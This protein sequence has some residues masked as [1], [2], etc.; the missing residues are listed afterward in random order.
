MS[1]VPNFDP[2]QL[3]FWDIYVQEEKDATIKVGGTMAG[4]FTPGLSGGQRKLFLFE[5]IYQRTLDHSGLLI[6][7][8]EPFAGVTDD[9]LPYIKKRLQQL[10]ERHAVIVVTNDHIDAL[11]G[12]ANHR[13]A[14]SA[15]DRSVVEIN[16]LGTFDREQVIRALHAGNEFRYRT[17]YE[18]FKF[19]F[20]LE[21]L[22]HRIF[23]FVLIYA[24]VTH[25]LTILTFWDS[26]DN[27]A[28]LVLSGSGIGGFFCLNVYYTS[29]VSWRT[30]MEQERDALLHD[31]KS[32]NRILKTILLAVA[33][34]LV[35][36]VA[37]Y[38]TANIVLGDVYSG[39]TMFVG[40]LTAFFDVVCL[41]IVLGVYTSYSF[42]TV[43]IYAALPFLLSNFLSTTMSPGG[44][45]PIVKELRYLFPRFYMWCMLPGVENFM[46]GCPENED[47][48]AWYMILSSLTGL[49]LFILG[50]C[51]FAVVPRTITKRTG[52][53]NRKPLEHASHE[54]EECK[55]LQEILYGDND[56]T[57]S[58]YHGH[59]FSSSE[60]L[61][62]FYH[63]TVQESKTMTVI[64]GS[65]G[66]GKTTF[67]EDV[68]RQNKCVYI[69]QFHSMRPYIPVTKI[70]NFD[71]T[72][73]PFWEIYASDEKDPSIQVG[74]TMAGVFTPGLSGGQRKLLLFELVCQRIEA[75]SGLLI[76]LD[77]PFAG[78]TEDFLLYIMKRLNEMRQ[79][80]NVILVTNDHVTHL[81]KLANCT[82]SLS[83]K[84]R[85]MVNVNDVED[86]DREV[87]ILA[88]SMGQPFA[89][90]ATDHDL[91]FF[92]DV[93]S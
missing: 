34:L 72:R 85:E 31:S 21:V 65:S 8:D 6:A 4:H 79:K 40:T 80:H 37:Q 5:L 42:E 91:K 69:R 32:F 73:L 28:P 13:I 11:K 3:P 25:A 16:K 64:V 54:S 66:S 41:N 75:Y 17:G 35:V 62:S 59:S 58:T 47:F 49:V 84:N 2:T 20:V 39:F 23:P 88:T 56:M 26:N 33:L 86:V 57:G 9:F 10:K 12:M 43:Q 77:E 87:A 30:A 89:M 53:Q 90:T 55:T 93:E 27:L 22:S 36:T 71:P 63:G 68:H 1:K 78:V 46:E 67:L 18:D 82:V 14:V 51:I 44:G 45:L 29:L 92:L 38:A 81:T 24:A 76:A 15:Q 19:F 50:Q 48:I 61:V 7:L 52:G 74:G 60:E 83:A 70:P